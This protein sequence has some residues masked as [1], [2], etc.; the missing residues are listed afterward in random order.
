MN[1]RERKSQAKN[2]RE[3]CIYATTSQTSTI[4]CLVTRRWSWGRRKGGGIIPALQTNRQRERRQSPRPLTNKLPWNSKRKRRQ[5]KEADVD[6]KAKAYIVSFVKEQVSTVTII[7]STTM[8]TDNVAPGNLFLNTQAEGA[9][10]KPSPV[11][12]QNNLLKWFSIR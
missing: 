8:T 10:A 2:W 4:S 7:S 1:F 12:K 6:N 3:W 5:N 11:K 9:A